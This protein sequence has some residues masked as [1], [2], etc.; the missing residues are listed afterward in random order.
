MLCEGQLLLWPKSLSWNTAVEKWRTEKQGKGLGM[1]GKT[2]TCDLEVS[3]GPDLYTEEKEDWEERG[4][5][6]S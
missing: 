6:N 3:L 5:F 1:P 2:Q 4:G